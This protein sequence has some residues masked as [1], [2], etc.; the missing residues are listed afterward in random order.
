MIKSECMAHLATVESVC[1]HKWTE[2]LAYGIE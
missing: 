2:K 1:E